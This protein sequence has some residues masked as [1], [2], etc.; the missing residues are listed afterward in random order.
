MIKNLNKNKKKKNGFTLIELI[1]VIAI[2]GILAAVA[3]PKFGEVRKN[4][5]T[6][7]DIANAKTIVNAV[8]SLMA[9]G[10]LTVPSATGLKLDNVTADDTIDND[11]IEGYLQSVPTPKSTTAT[12]FYVYIDGSGGVEVYAG[13]KPVTGTANRFFPQ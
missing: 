6:N 10:S 9:E 12:N 8:T 2:I 13:V 7:A 11:K 4:A 5:N 3:I 1:I